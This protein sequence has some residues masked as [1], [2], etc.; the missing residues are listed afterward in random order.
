MGIQHKHMDVSLLVS[1]TILCSCCA[2]TQGTCP[3]VQHRVLFGPRSNLDLDKQLPVVRAAIKE[4]CEGLAGPG[5]PLYP[6]C[7]S[8]ELPGREPA[9]EPLAR[10]RVL[11]GKVRDDEPAPGEPLGHD[12]GDGQRHGARLGVVVA[13]RSERECVCV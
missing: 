8:A 7:H 5:E 11:R 9:A 12:G 13:V 6:R 1:L 10:G 3:Y 4:R 2:G